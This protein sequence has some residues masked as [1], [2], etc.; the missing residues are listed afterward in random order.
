MIN[1]V[2]SHRYWATSISNQTV[3]QV[4]LIINQIII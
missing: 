4:Q 2:F 1:I 3:Y